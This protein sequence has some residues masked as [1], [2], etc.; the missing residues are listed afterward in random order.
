VRLLIDE[1]LSPELARDAQAAGFEAYHLVHLGRAG[2]QDWNIA[3]FA[4]DQDMILVTNNRAICM[5]DM[6]FTLG[7][8]LLCLASAEK[9]S[10]GCSGLRW[11]SHPGS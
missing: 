7:W 1:C 2:W 5:S 11:S 3:G 8:L 4:V 9:R 6:A 10:R